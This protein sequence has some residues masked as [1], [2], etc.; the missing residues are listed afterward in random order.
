MS[1]TAYDVKPD[2]TGVYVTNVFVCAIAEI[3]S[4]N[5]TGISRFKY[6]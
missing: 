6:I 2:Q 3:D 1:L 4:A 5:I